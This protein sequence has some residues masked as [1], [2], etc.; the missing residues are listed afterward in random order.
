MQ[1]RGKGRPAGREHR[2]ARGGL[3]VELNRLPRGT[4]TEKLARRR[5]TPLARPV[6]GAARDVLNRVA[7]P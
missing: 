6:H 7:D 3:I 1:A 4:G 5:P 2:G